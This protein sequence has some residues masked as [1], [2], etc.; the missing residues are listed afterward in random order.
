MVDGVTYR[1]RIRKRPTYCQGNGWGTMSYAVDL[2]AAP[3]CTLV[4]DTGHPRPD[5]WLSL[6]APSVLPSQV[7][8]AIRA[9]L[10]RG[11]VPERP[12]S[13]FLYSE[14]SSPT[15]SVHNS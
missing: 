4:V 13:P 14:P 1:W 2:P 9:A 5:N 7:A 12:G 11:W 6:P 8:V 10:A 15:P 3:R